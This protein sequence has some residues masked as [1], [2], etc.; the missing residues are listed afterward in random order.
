[1]SAADLGMPNTIGG[2]KLVK[3]LSSIEISEST[4]VKDYK[5]V[6]DITGMCY[7][8]RIGFTSARSTQA[9]CRVTIDGQVFEKVGYGSNLAIVGLQ[10]TNYSEG[11]LPPLI[12][13]ERVIVEV[14]N[15]TSTDVLG[16]F[17]GSLIQLEDF[18]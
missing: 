15:V 8:R 1:M 12:A 11:I 16:Q 18:E 7:V 13:K 9:K 5:K 6:A 14:A 4:S 10:D 2:G 17:F 3:H